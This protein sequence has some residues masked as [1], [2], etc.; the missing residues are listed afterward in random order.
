[1]TSHKIQLQI[2]DASILCCAQMMNYNDF[3]LIPTVDP[4]E[5]TVMTIT[6]WDAIKQVMT[7]CVIKTHSP[8]RWLHLINA[9]ATELHR[10]GNRLIVPEDLIAAAKGF[11]QRLTVFFKHCE[12]G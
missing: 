6:D 4:F 12:A 5:W 10:T 2:A 11:E 9:S 8:A 3:V 1:M 7:N